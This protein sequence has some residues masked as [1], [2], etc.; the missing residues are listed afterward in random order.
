MTI[1]KKTPYWF[2]GGMILSIL[3]LLFYGFAYVL[4]QNNPDGQAGLVFITPSIPLMPFFGLLI[5]AGLGESLFSNLYLVFF[6]TAIFYFVIGSV[7]GWIWGKIVKSK[8]SK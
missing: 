8:A 6:C 5:M 4:I 2:R 1:Y 7:I 3:L